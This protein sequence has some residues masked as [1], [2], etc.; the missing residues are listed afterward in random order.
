VS[1]N[2]LGL[3][4]I[5]LLLTSFS[6][7]ALA[8]TPTTL[9]AIVGTND[10]YN[11]TLNDASGRKVSRLA[12]GTYT[13]VVD[14]RSKLHNFHLASNDDPTVD[15]RT[16]LDFVGQQSFTV[17]FKE[18]QRVRVR[19]RAALAG[20]ER[21]LLRERR[22]AITAASAAASPGPD[23]ESLG[24][25]RG[26]RPPQR[27]LGSERPLQGRRQRSLVRRQLASGRPRGEQAHRHPL[28]GLG[29]VARAPGAR[30]VQLLERP[31]GPKKRLRVR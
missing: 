26:C 10:G 21:L 25:R 14:D 24:L 22:S 8:D 18:Q 4:I 7:S 20:H 1:S 5:A 27:V 13:V 28:Q 3:V 6:G 17:T 15:F 19:L 23:A 16:E 29:D 9:N 12:P 31:P 11:I 2:A 30:D